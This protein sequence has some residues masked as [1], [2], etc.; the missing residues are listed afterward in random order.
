MVTA[1]TYMNM[2]GP[3]IILLV[4]MVLHGDQLVNVQHRTLSFKILDREV[5]CIVFIL[6]NAPR[7][8]LARNPHRRIIQD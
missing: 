3:V 2:V 4:I 8:R 1:T 5:K 7:F 6:L